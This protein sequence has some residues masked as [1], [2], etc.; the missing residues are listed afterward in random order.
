MK[1]EAPK[2]VWS[3]QIRGTRREIGLRIVAL[4]QERSLSQTEL[5]DLLG[6]P[7]ERLAKWEGG[8]HAP[9]PEDLIALA[10][11][12]G[13]TTD[14][15]LIGRTTHPGREELWEITEQIQVLAA[16]LKQLT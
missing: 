1:S 6:V 11:V 14:E 13:V 3:G 2:V 4:R 9:P 12:F 8:H 5:A 15:I 7:R 16:R 10:A